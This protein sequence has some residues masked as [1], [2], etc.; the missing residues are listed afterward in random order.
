MTK[1]SNVHHLPREY[2]E[3]Y[4]GD[5][6][7]PLERLHAAGLL[8]YAMTESGYDDPAMAHFIADG[9]MA[10]VKNL[11]EIEQREELRREAE[12]S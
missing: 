12:T 7:L 8:L 4:S 1:K 3:L 11:R 10:Q 9:I 6:D 5:A 2:Y